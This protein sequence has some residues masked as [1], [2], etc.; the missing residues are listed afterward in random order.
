MQRNYM[1]VLCGLVVDSMSTAWGKITHLYTNVIHTLS[2]MGVSLQLIQEFT[3]NNR[4]L[5]HTLNLSVN[6]EFYTLSTA[7]TTRAH[8]KRRI[9]L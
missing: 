9:N 3:H 1:S 5:L 4:S 6:Y 8:N 7:P 2:A